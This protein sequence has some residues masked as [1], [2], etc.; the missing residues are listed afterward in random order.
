M[1]ETII[2]IF[3]CTYHEQCFGQT[4]KPELNFMCGVL[5]LS[6]FSGYLTEP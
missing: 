3:V 4:E 1:K 2:L 6:S 5:S